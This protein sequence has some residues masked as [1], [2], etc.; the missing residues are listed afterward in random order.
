MALSESLQPA[1]NPSEFSAR[2]R[3]SCRSGDYSEEYP[4]E[5]S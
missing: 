1:F 4:E 2:G 5:E 3:L